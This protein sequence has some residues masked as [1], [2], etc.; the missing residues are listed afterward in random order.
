MNAG[1][2]IDRM[3][4]FMKGMD[5]DA[6]QDAVQRGVRKTLAGHPRTSDVS[7]FVEEHPEICTY[8]IRY[9]AAAMGG[10]MYRTMMQWL[11]EE[12][13]RSEESE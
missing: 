3:T 13:E 6:M 7:L 4:S 5:I 12:K 2:E 11:M 8:I 10:E 9:A 1:E